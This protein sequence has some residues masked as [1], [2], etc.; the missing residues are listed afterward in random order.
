MLYVFGTQFLVI[1]TIRYFKVPAPLRISSIPK[2][3]QLRPAVYFIT[4][5]VCAVDGGGGVEYRIALN[6]RY[7]ASHVF[8][9]MMRRLGMFWAVGAEAC[10]V[11][12]TV[13]IFALDDSQIG[14]VIGWSAPFV[15][16]GIWA[17]ATVLYVK[18]ELRK[19]KAIWATE[20]A[21]ARV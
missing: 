4:E 14:Y 6:R 9:V 3:A 19:E 10:A 18:R 1:D 21:K 7:E 20:A 12:C 15:W 13:L 16:A 2:G 5:D 8:R 17:S 11:L